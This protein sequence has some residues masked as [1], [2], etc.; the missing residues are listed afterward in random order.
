MTRSDPPPAVTGRP[1]TTRAEEAPPTSCL[2][3]EGSAPDVLREYALL[4]DG[5]RGALLGPRGDVGSRTAGSWNAARLW[6][7]R[8]TNIGLCCCA[9]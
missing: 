7:F 5:E 9:A 4:A 3:N 2:T 6:H 1:V 8:E